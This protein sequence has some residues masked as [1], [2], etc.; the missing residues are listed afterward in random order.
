[1]PNP[2]FFQEISLRTSY[3]ASPYETRLALDLLHTGRIRP[4]TV[5]THQFP[6]REAAKA[7]QLV[8][9]PGDAL[10]VVITAR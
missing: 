5:I 1:M 9:R 8:A 2:L 10:K 4:E 7:F 6:L 3:S